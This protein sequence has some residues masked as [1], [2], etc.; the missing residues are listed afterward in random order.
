MRKQVDFSDEQNES[1][2]KIQKEY[3]KEFQ[4]I[5]KNYP[6]LSKKDLPKEDRKVLIKKLRDE[7][8]KLRKK[9]SDEAEEIL[10]PHQMTMIKS[11]RFKQS[12]QMIGLSQT[13]TKAPFQEDF[14]TTDSQK[15][16]LLEIQA[17]SQKAIQEKVMEMQKEMAKMKADAKKKML[18]VLNSKQKKLL[19]ELEGEENKNGNND[20]APAIRKVFPNR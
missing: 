15:K 17:E 6:E 19:K 11:I 12:V 1:F 14:E 9:F 7:Q 20:F 18:K 3:W 5:S 4:S 2:V 8:A 13:I 16:E 10:V